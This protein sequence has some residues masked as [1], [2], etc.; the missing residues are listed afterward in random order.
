VGS[1]CV[2]YPDGAV[3][4]FHFMQRTV[5]AAGHTVSV[6]SF[7]DPRLDAEIVVGFGRSCRLAAA[8]PGAAGVW[9]SP[10]FS[11]QATAEGLSSSSGPGLVIGSVDD[12]AWDRSAAARLRQFEI[13]QIP[14]VDREF[15][16]PGD[17]VASLRVFERILDRVSALSRRIP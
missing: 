11:D 1:R 7:E 16:V 14:H 13:L 2:M 12:P 8:V 4:L 5:E 17:P 6:A 15:E 3:P 10:D 9:L